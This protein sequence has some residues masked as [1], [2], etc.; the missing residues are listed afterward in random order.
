MTASILSD[1]ALFDL[2]CDLEQT[3]AVIEHAERATRSVKKST[4]L[5]DPAHW[6]SRFAATCRSV[7]E[8]VAYQRELRLQGHAA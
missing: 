6:R 4:V 3:L 2:I 1:R 5:R 8:A 7:R